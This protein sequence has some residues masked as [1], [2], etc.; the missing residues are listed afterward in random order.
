[1]LKLTSE[2]YYSLEANQ[3]YWSASFIKSMQEC[4]A[5]A[6][7]ELE[8]KYTRPITPA[9]LIG[10][11][12]DSYFK[13]TLE[14]FKQDHPELLKRDGTLKAEYLKANDMIRRAERDPIF[15]E[16]LQGKKQVILTGRIEGLSF[17][18]KL[19]VYLPG[20]RIVDLKTAKDME[21][22]YRPGQ[23]KLSFAEYWN[24]PLQMAIYQL[25]EGNRLPCYLAVITKE[26][27]PNIDVI[28]I[29][30][31][32]LDA[33]TE[34]LKERLP[35]FDAIRTKIIEPPRC[36]KCAYC[37]N[38]KRLS[39]PTSLDSLIEFEGETI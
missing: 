15:M 21:P 3:A 27:P 7:A 33:E 12:V 34:V 32:A 39:G 30:Q 16:Y 6:I 20:K 26:D 38:T 25:T 31:H 10:S 37:R 22:M 24:W 14:S 13:G 35:Y 11:Y 9:L 19:D 2:N 4:P 1:M 23:G 5:R 36:E 8:G 18:S 28:E 29:P 17:K